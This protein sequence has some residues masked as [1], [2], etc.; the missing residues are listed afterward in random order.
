MADETSRLVIAVDSTSAKVATGDLDGLTAASAKAEAATASLGQATNAFGETQADVDARLRSVAQAYRAELEASEA[1]TKAAYDAAASRASAAAAASTQ[2]AASAK[3]VQSQNAQMASSSAA[4]AAQSQY[5]RILATTAG[6]S[7][8]LD[9]AEAQLNKLRAAG[10]ITS[11]EYAAAV[12]RLAKAKLTDAAASKVAAAAEKEGLTARQTREIG[13]L[14]TELAA[15][16]T[17]RVK[18]STAALA[19]SF[20]I[21]GKLMTP[22]GLAV[23][24]VA[25]AIG[26][27]VAAMVAGERET[28]AYNHALAASGTTGVTTAGQLRDL[29]TALGAANGS[30]GDAREIVLALTQA[31]LASSAMFQTAAQA[32]S[33]YAVATGT[34]AADAA[35]TVTA[36]MTG[37][38]DAISKVDQAYQFLT[39]SQLAHIRALAD[40][41]RAT[42]AAREA[43]Q[44]FAD[45][46]A[47]TKGQAVA[48]AGYIETAWNKVKGAIGGAI[49]S[50]KGWGAA[51]SI[52]AQLADIQKQ[53]DN[54]ATPGERAALQAHF[55]PQ[56]NQLRGQ[57]MFQNGQE[58]AA[59]SRQT[60]EKNAKDASAYLSQFLTPQQL[61]GNAMEKAL[62]AKEVALLAPSLTASDKANIESQY[63]VAVKQAQDALQ[64]AL[65]K[66]QPKA[67]GHKADPLAGMQSMINSL[68]ESA[69]KAEGPVGDFLATVAKLTTARD[70][71]IKKGADAGQA[72]KLF[73]EGVAIANQ[74]LKEQETQLQ[75]RNKV[76]MDQFTASLQRQLE[77]QRQQN[78]L[79][80][81]SI[82]MG[83]QDY[84]RQSQLLQIQQQAAQ[85]KFEM[86]Q[87]AQ[88]SIAQINPQAPGAQSQIDQI[89]ATLNAQL[90]AYDAYT[91]QHLALTQQMYAGED[92][93][94]SDWVNGV[95]SAY[96]D[97]LVQ[98][99][100][101]ASMAAKE[102]NDFASGVSDAFVQIVQGGESVKKAFGSVIDTMLSDALRF[103]ANQAVV[104]MMGWLQNLGN[105]GS[106]GDVALGTSAVSSGGGGFWGTA[107]S[108]IG[109]F[110]GGGRANGGPVSPYT[111]YQVNERGTPEL[112]AV[113]GKTFLMMGA[114]GGTVTPTQSARGG[115][116][117]TNISVNVQPTMSRRT[118]DQVAL[119]VSREQQL[120]TARA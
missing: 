81:A 28:A 49:D 72:E 10:V 114:Q 67:A 70:A 86:Q 68:G 117:V 71:A 1:S 30:Y 18:T 2:S 5:E 87:R 55:Q 105:N 91:Q 35:R 94:R 56:I 40:Q 100:D 101:F 74:R 43:L 17:G 73:A 24:G 61:F 63:D 38:F 103:I 118:A 95:K 119:T 27:L 108:L 36:L 75:Q 42:D 79:Q 120:A 21:V 50:L 16:N 65:K 88:A 80:V 44:L 84:Q 85:R 76:A 9:A 34:K 45:K 41:G 112:L 83:Q 54:T 59:A 20:G 82:G 13:T 52:A 3:L 53:I 33:D 11:T 90:Q 62:H 110:F 92:S 6:T 46:S 106:G 107:A 111:S 64:R 14:A 60:I 116:G 102:F 31:G 15:G 37:H 12:D 113:G 48:D 99:Q 58:L 7:A 29:A 69:L 47:S 66:D 109:S 93:M 115:V 39:T 51:Q 25:V 4:V 22:V 78:A 97:L 8:E 32:A 57:Q 104:K 23:T 19:N 96:A 89:N 26:G 98:S 77:V